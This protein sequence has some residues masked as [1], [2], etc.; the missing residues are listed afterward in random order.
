[1]KSRRQVEK[2]IHSLGWWYQHFEFPNGA[3]TGNGQEPGYDVQ[4]RWDI[5]K[6]FIP[7]D[8]TGSTVL[9]L[10]GNAGFFAAQ[11]KLRGASKCVLVDPFSEFIEQARFT[12]SQFEVDLEL[13]NDDAHTFCLTNE[14]QFDYVIFLGLLYHLKYPGLVLD[15][16]AEMTQK[17][18]FIHS[19]VIGEHHQNYTEKTNYERTR[20]SNLLEDPAYPKMLFIENDYNGDPTNWW[21]PNYQ[22][23]AALVRSAGLKIIERPHSELIIAEP[24]ISFGKVVLTKLVFP[25][26]GKR[27]KA[28]YPGPQRY[29]SNLWLDLIERSKESNQDEEPN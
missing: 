23:L 14:E 21:I 27:G 26:Y 25:K 28:I 18:I 20:D 8:L 4:T 10:G 22:G 9:D 11:M 5:I 15:R 24:E 19:H 16:L 13:I 29:D 6:P 17:R 3:R 2:M 7:E 12:A 1:M